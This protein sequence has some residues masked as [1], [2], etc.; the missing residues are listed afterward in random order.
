MEQVHD[1]IDIIQ[2]H[3]S[4]L[5]HAFHVMGAHTVFAQLFLNVLT[6][7]AY[8]RI[9]GAARDDE[10]VRHIGDT[11]EPEDHDVVRLVI[12]G[13]QR[14]ATGKIRDGRGLGV[15]A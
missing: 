2:Q 6:E 14:G 1:E 11:F 9:R 15:G 7:R 8:V 12:C 3:P 13:D 5:L 10:K 4:A